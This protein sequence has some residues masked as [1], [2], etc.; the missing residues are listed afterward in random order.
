MNDDQLPNDPDLQAAANGDPGRPLPA[1]GADAPAPD[2]APNEVVPTVDQPTQVMPVAGD[3][4][5]EREVPVETVAPAAAVVD[6]YPAQTYAADPVPVDGDYVFEDEPNAGKTA[7]IVLVALILLG[8]LGYFLY[9]ASKDDED[10][11]RTDRNV[12]A[13]VDT[14][15][16]ETAP[17]TDTTPTIPQDTDPQTDPNANDTPTTSE[18]DPATGDDPTTTDPN[19][20]TG[21][22]TGTGQGTNGQDTPSD[23]GT[24]EPAAPKTPGDISSDTDAYQGASVSVVG[25]AEQLVNDQAFVS[26]S[27]L[28]VASAVTEELATGSSYRISGTVGKVDDAFRQRVGPDFFRDMSYEQLRG[29]AVIDGAKVT[30]Q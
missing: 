11:K 6:T 23:P 7:A 30:P 16:R 20:G 22:G 1:P 4:I 2:E 8:L 29:L 18:P 21:T 28:V 17:D 10:D 12:P 9:Q 13:A 25:P 15:Q 14:D 27:V 19:P 3:I 5:T 26:E 24:Q